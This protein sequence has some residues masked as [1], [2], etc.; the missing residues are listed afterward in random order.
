MSK[1]SNLL[2]ELTSDFNRFSKVLKSASKTILTEDVSKYPIFIVHRHIVNMGIPLIDPEK[3]G[4]KWS[5]NASTLEEFV[6][7]NLI[8]SSKVDD[9]KKIYKNPELYICLFVLEKDDANFIFIPY[10]RRELNN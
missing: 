4:S 2:Q 8:E 5:F 10:V 7:K 3:S 9:F 1:E 6:S